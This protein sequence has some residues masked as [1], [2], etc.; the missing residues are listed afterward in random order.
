MHDAIMI[1]SKEEKEKKIN[2]GFRLLLEEQKVR[3]SVE[4]DWW[5]T[6]C[7][8]VVLD[9]ALT[10]SAKYRRVLFINYDVNEFDHQHT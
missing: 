6:F 1:R 7:L 5:R 3:Y 9:I 10:L 2:Q 8:S 4:G